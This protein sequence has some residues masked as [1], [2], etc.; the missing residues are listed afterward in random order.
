MFDAF[1]CLVE[2]A[3]VAMM[4][5]SVAFAAWMAWLVWRNRR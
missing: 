2:A 1:L 4:I 3:F 5:A